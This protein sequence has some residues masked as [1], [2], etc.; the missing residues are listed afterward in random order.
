MKRR[1]FIKTSAAFAG[2]Q[3][4]PKN[5][6]A[7]APNSKLAVAQIGTAGM[8]S[9]DLN[10]V[11]DHARVVITGLCDID[12]SRMKDPG[13]KH[14][15]AKQ[16]QDYREMFSTMGDKLDAVVV[17]TPD[18]THAP[19]SMLA[20]NLGK[21]VYCQKPLTHSVYESRRMREVAAEKK[22]V[23]QMGIQIHAHVAYRMAT[24]LIQSGAIGK[25]KKVVAWSN[26]NWGTDKPAPEGSDPVPENIDWN[27]W[28]GVAPMR[29][30]KSGVYHPG[31]WRR[32]LDFGCGNL[33]D[34]GVHIFDTPY[35][36]LKLT[37]PKWVINRCRPP[38]GFGHPESN[39][40]EYLFPGT[41][42]TTDTLSWIW[43]DGSLAPPKNH[44]WDLP[45]NYKLPAQA[46]MFEGEEGLMI[47]PHVEGPQ[48]FPRE[49]FAAIPRPK[50][51]ALNHYHQW[52][53]GC[54]GLTTPSAN[55][56]YAGPLTESLLLGVL[57]NRFPNTQLEWDPVAFKF[58][59][60]PEANAFLRRKYRDGFEVAGL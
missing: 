39:E 8:G 32:L 14:P 22:L 37:A 46:A 34:M 11:A 18:H 44:G 57:A 20:M 47:L 54:L 5:V 43:T 58:T 1:V 41:Q 55:F 17:S 45:E 4:L 23:T 12:V 7:E 40:V 56:D 36:A 50:P 27:L 52:V 48:F 29:P 13:N 28:L 10:S 53:D 60:K 38:T 31:N 19:A 21:H 35:R 24:E 30:F 15:D 9:G 42:Y 16:F 51:P 6:L 26:K 2:I 49:K 25:V 59:N 33:G 3:I